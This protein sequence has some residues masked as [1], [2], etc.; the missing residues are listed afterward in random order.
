MVRI[1]QCPIEI[2]DPVE[3]VGLPQPLVDFLANRFA[4]RVPRAGKERLVLER[5]KRADDDL[6]STRLAAHGEL[7]QPPDHLWRGDLFFG[8]ADA[9]SQIVGAQYDDGVGNAGLCQN[10]A[11]EATE[12][13][14][15]DG[16]V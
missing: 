2:D 5:D 1:A 12:A 13:A 9:V 8:L 7:L 10:V 3:R 4:L 14:V 11:V 6:Y 15:D 16:V